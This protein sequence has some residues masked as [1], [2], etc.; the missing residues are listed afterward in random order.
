MQLF[1]PKNVQKVEKKNAFIC[2]IVLFEQKNEYKVSKTP[3]DF[4]VTQG[5]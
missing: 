4:S 5:T 3:I 1:A 2:H